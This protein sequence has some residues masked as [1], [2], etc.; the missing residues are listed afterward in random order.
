MSIDKKYLL[1]KY[2]SIESSLK[3]SKKKKSK[4]SK[5]ATIIDEDG[6][7]F[8]QRDNDDELEGIYFYLFYLF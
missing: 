2:G 7:D 4:T 3:P 5:R 8:W 6:D 1:S